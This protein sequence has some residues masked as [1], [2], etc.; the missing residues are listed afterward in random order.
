MTTKAQR[1]AI[2]EEKVN[3][4]KTRI[5]EKKRNSDLYTITLDTLI[6]SY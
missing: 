5:L 3:A 6:E 4:E 1:K 2:I